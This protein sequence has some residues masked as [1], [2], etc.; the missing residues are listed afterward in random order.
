[1]DSFSIL[2][3]VVDSLHKEIESLWRDDGILL[4]FLS[5]ANGYRFAAGRYRWE[6]T[7]HKLYTGSIRPSRRGNTLR[8]VFVVV[9]LVHHMHMH[10]DQVT[11]QVP[12][13]LIGLHIS[14]LV[15]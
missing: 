2:R 15:G 8:L 12:Y 1:V 4:V 9:W 10:D 11:D 6:H 7:E 5:P 13:S 14:F 3:G